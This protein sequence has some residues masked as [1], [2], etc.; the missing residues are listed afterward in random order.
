PKFDDAEEYIS[1]F[2]EIFENAGIKSVTALSMEVPCCSGLTTIVKK[3]MDISGKKIPMEEV[4][5]S[6]KG[7]ILKRK[8]IV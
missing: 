2:A 3:G 5:V 1:Q 6:T 4:V 8:K 7:N